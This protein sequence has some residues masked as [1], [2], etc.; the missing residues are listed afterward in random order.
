[1]SENQPVPIQDL[2]H[3]ASLIAHWHGNGVAQLRQMTQMP[4]GVEVSYTDESGKEIT[5]S[6]DQRSGF[7]AGLVVAM[8]VFQKL[9]FSA[10]PVE[11]EPVQ[12]PA[13]D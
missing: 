10:L 4:E 7:I 5:L 3:F 9:P 12:E 13:H 1:M 6:P 11:E 8:D 2:D